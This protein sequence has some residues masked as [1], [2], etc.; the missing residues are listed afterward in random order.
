[1]T[2]LPYDRITIDANICHGKHCIRGLRYPVENI[3]EWLSTGMSIEEIIADY[4]DL[5]RED[6]MAALVFATQVIKVKR[7]AKLAA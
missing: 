2:A 7:I 1:M 4:D 5:E 3:L 6:I